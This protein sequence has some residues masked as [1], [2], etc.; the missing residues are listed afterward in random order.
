MPRTT[1]A[2]RAFA[3]S[4]L[5]LTLVIA[6]PSAQAANSP[7]AVGSAQVPASATTAA[8]TATDAATAATTG[9]AA[10]DPTYGASRFI[11]GGGNGW[12]GPASRARVFG[13]LRTDATTSGA[14]LVASTQRSE[15]LRVDSASDRLTVVPGTADADPLEVRDV[16][17]DGTGIV[18]ATSAGVV[19]I[20]ADG[21]RATLSTDTTVR[22]VDVGSDGVVWAASYGQVVRILTDGTVQEA[23]APDTLV[24][25]RDIAV[26]PDGQRL[27]VM[28]GGDNRV[29]V[30]QVTAAGLGARI[31]GNGLRTD[32]G[33]PP[34]SVATLVSLDSVF[35]L[36]TDGTTLW[37]GSRAHGKVVRVPTA[38]GTT[39]DA[40]AGRRVDTVERVGTGLAVASYEQGSDSWGVHRF[41]ADGAYAGRLVG[42][43]PA[44]PWSPDGVS[45]ADAYLD[46][47]RGGAA[48][49][50]GLTVFTTDTGRVYEV[51][52]DGLLRTRATIPALKSGGKVALAADGTAYVVTDAGGV[53]RVPA[54]GAPTAAVP[55]TGAV[56]VEVDADGSLLV[57]DGPGKR[58][59]RFASGSSSLV[60]TL[61]ITP[62]DIGRDGTG[63]L[64]AGE[65][66]HRV[67]PGSTVTTLL[68]GGSFQGVARIAEGTFLDNGL[69]FNGR[70]VLLP[71]GALAPMRAA[72]NDSA[73]QTQAVGDDLLRSGGMS[74]RL[75]SDPGLAP[76][77]D[78]IAVTATPGSGRVVLDWDR[79]NV[80][81]AVVRAKKGSAPVDQ[82]DGLPVDDTRTV[83][84]IGS[85]TLV[86]GEEWVFSVFFY[87]AVPWPDPWAPLNLSA[88]VVVSAASLLDSDP[89][90]PPIEPHTW[91]TRTAT[92]VQWSDPWGDD[93]SHSV[94]RYLP[95]TTAP[96]TPTDGLLLDGPVP[97][98]EPDKDYAISVFTIDI[99]DNYSKWSA[100]TRVDVRPPGPVTDV[101][102]TP[103]FSTAAATVTM[104]T[105]ADFI[106]ITFAVAA[107]DAVPELPPNGP[108]KDTSFTVYGLAM[109]R[110]YTL[111]VWTHDD[112]GNISE[113]V[114]TT[115]RSALD[116]SAPGTVGSL[117]AVGGDYRVDATWTPPTDPDLK[118]LRVTLVDTTKGTTGTPTT[119]AKTAT[120]YGW[121]KQ[122]GGHHF[123]V[124]VT[125][126]D[127]N[128]NVS[129]V[130]TA[131]T[132]TNADANGGPDPIDP[133]SV[134]VTPK[135]SSTVSISF[136][137]PTIPDLRNLAYAITEVG[138]DPDTVTSV[139][140]LTS[141]ATVT[142]T[143]TLPKPL[144]AYQ[145]VLYVW[146]F[147]GNRGRSLIP[148]VAG[149][150]TPT[151]LPAAPALLF[152]HSNY[153][154]EIDVSWGVQSNTARPVDWVVTAT[155]GALTRTTVVP[156]TQLTAWFL[157]V[158][159]R[160]DWTVSV[161][162][163]NASGVGPTKTAASVRVDDDTAPAPVTKLTTVP[164]YDSPT[165]TWVNPTAFDFD[166]VVVTRYG[167]TA[168]ETA[169]L[170]TGKGTSARVGALVNGRHY[171]LVV[172]A[173]DAFG[174][175][176]A[177]PSA[178][179]VT[180]STVTMSIGTK[181]TYPGTTRA[182]GTLRWRGQPL[183]GRALI[184]QGQAPG[185]TSWTKVATTTTS[186]TGTYAV[187]LKPS[188]ITRYRV[189]Y[190]GTTTNGGAVGATSTVT[191]APSV[192]IRASRSSFALGGSATLSTTV[193]PNHKGR[194][195]S[196]QRWTGT[197]WSTVATRTLSST[198]T[199][200]ASVKPT[201]RGT[202]SYRWVLPSH[203]DHGTGV[204]ATLKLSVS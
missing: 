120:G 187:T 69:S 198:S 107:G 196:L 22:R 161:M 183:A 158:P 47:V 53:T 96:A 195:I 144:T 142:A 14:L 89:P 193:G 116:S 32:S 76:Q 138:A 9:T 170:Y 51:R 98:A 44:Q 148:S 12:T 104:P 35:S 112:V 114:L 143:I 131:T 33:I 94:A 19:R 66:L 49:P 88:P 87:E 85:S 109:D 168:A 56:D 152:V 26:S 25:I 162:G 171:W 199:A 41:A 124:R 42:R 93:F 155:S 149:E 134:T 172:A 24:A 17:A 181:V 167:D 105:D 184:V 106:G 173:Y 202:N 121:P 23:T 136:P 133:A 188:A 65:G 201:K 81:S 182:T 83:L 192:S 159:G 122:P 130:A 74:V 115:F 45:A 20:A 102:V 185:A 52:S 150:F 103:S 15:V 7:E 153:D 82:W 189:V 190:L 91:R 27:Y 119:L 79:P 48:L 34:G 29:G 1:P 90:P 3:L 100:V 8:T 139:T 11:A 92:G 197:A 151:E 128:G 179:E 46:V 6:A 101:H 67:V 186:T 194:T 141:A 204:S 75:V 40:A 50:S 43:D 123:E 118:D 73:S 117:V 110:D 111:A 160:L 18:L 169:V 38:G 84:H 57:A 55:A 175:T 146:D 176:A 2:V 191:V 147:N 108:S 140:P 200:S 5:A 125:G 71:G 59:L 16:A 13:E 78:P 62:T 31:A 156:G 180:Q 10:I 163:R 72:D 165:V 70:V 97:G 137:R 154:N 126:T 135:T 4:T 60:A 54:T 113:P 28:D 68:T 129:E 95:G 132:D 145:L 203:T 178:V 77:P 166:H 99:H 63:I 127:V 37:L 21:T 80:A 58:L 64:I 39:A 61:P 157:D 177:E 36:A 164:S 30:Y 174:N 86:P